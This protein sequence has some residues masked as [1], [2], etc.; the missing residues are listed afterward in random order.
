MIE[1]CSLAFGLGYVCYATNAAKRL[2]WRTLIIAAALGSLAATVKI[3]TFLPLLI[4]VIGY[5]LFHAV[6][7]R[8]SRKEMLLQ[9]AF[10]LAV[11]A[12]LGLLWAAV[13]SRVD[14]L[15]PLYLKAFPPDYLRVWV[16]GTLKDRF[17][18]EF[19]GTFFHRVLP[20]TLGISWALILIFAAC[21]MAVRRYA[22]AVFVASAMFLLPILIYPRL[23]QIH[24]YYQ[25]ENAFFLCAACGF[26]VCGLLLKPGLGRAA[27]WALLLFVVA[28]GV[29]RYYRIFYPSAHTDFLRLKLV[30]D[31]VQS[32]TTPQQLIIVRGEDWSS[33]VPFY[34]QRRA[35]MD[36]D[37]SPELLHRQVAAALPA[38]VADV[39][40]CDAARR[41][42]ENLDVDEKLEKVSQMYGVKMSR[43]LDDGICFHFTNGQ[44]GRRL[45]PTTKMTGSMP[46]LSFLDL[47]QNGAEVAGSFTTAG[48]VLSLPLTKEIDVEIDGKPVASGGT[49]GIRLDLM[50]PFPKY[51]GHPFN[52]F[53]I[54]VSSKGLSKG[55]HVL[56]LHAVLEDG[57]D[58]FLGET[59]I[60][61][62]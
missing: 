17:S 23:H 26:A 34:S 36:R 37:F 35:I 15:N 22:V 54:Q 31:R 46:F 56:S 21:L 10:L 2:T 42:L 38:Q 32:L 58:H 7:Q 25:T 11:P 27:G 40:F 9:A 12:A 16:F 52:G 30:G 57:S 1:T 48:W 49:G 18:S 4:L 50:Q 53:N 39:V 61:K 60:F 28:A 44:P 55:D 59:R 33:E 51:P 13:F 47:P 14:Y 45:Q 62:R 41:E 20:D 43:S 5:L 3:T 19:W 24:D 6:S 8:V 29:A